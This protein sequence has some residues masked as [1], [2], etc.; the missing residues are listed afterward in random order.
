[1]RQERAEGRRPG[2]R[3]RFGIGLAAV[4]VGAVAL[5]GCDDDGV[6]GIDLLDE[7]DL[8]GTYDAQTL[9]VTRGEEDPVDALEA[10]ATITLRLNDDGTVGG[11]ISVPAEVTDG[12][13]IDEA[14]AGTWSF[15]EN[16]QR[17]DLTLAQDLSDLFL[18]DLVFVA[19]RQ[20]GDVLLE[21]EFID[22]TEDLSILVVL[23][24]R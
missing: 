16:L 8:D 15:D 2:A 22:T 20:G 11:A 4:L 7:N 12:E 21:G 9:E 24:R 1:M 18:D 3:R 19:Q 23:R 17:L 6:S 13:P 10:G 5:A 14:L